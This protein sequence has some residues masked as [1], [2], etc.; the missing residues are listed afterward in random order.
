MAEMLAAV[1]ILVVLGSLVVAS[2][3]TA[4]QVVK[5]S[6]YNS[7]A[8][9]LSTSINTALSDVLRYSQVYVDAEGQALLSDA[10]T[11]YIKP[12]STFLDASGA[13]VERGYFTNDG[14]IV[15]VSEVGGVAQAQTTPVPAATGIY[16][17]FEVRD[18]WLDYRAQTDAENH[19]VGNARYV[20][21][22]TLYTRDGTFAKS[23]EF[24]CRPNTGEILG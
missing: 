2:L 13:Q 22:Y 9:V 10:F 3:P 6:T 24:T 15:L 4:A 21:G 8:Q 20:G 12:S 1:A 14:V 18:F 19:F 23:Y 5:R 11:P 7:N 17:E 16:T